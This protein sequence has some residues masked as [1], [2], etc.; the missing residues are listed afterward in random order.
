MMFL[1]ECPDQVG[2]AL[3]ASKMLKSLADK[4]A[5]AKEQQLAN[6]MVSNARLKIFSYFVIMKH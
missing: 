6:E 2:S 3:M 4:A 1:K 5:S